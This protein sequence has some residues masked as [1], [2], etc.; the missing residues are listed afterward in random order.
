MKKFL[1]YNITAA[2]LILAA[3]I[4]LSVLFGFNRT[5]AALSADLRNVYFGE[6]EDGTGRY[7][8]V[9][10]AVSAYLDTAEE[11]SRLTGAP[12][13][14]EDAIRAAEPLRNSPFG[15]RDAF[16]R[17]ADAADS[18]YH[19]Y[20]GGASSDNGEVKAVY[21]AMESGKK[22]LSGFREYAA[23]VG[24]YNRTVSAFPGRFLVFGRPE[25]AVFEE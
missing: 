3:V 2:S 4:L 10:S 8:N 14:L 1:K 24:K 11:L 9:S 23:L 6:G 25:A 22:R 17:L 13:A 16:L 21:M 18:A 20:A 12:A 15:S 19:T 5:A 7:G